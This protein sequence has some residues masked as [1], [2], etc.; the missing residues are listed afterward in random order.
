[1]LKTT[2]VRNLLMGVVGIALQ[3][4]VASFGVAQERIVAPS[5]APIGVAPSPAPSPD[6]NPNLPTTPAPSPLPTPNPAVNPTP[7]VRYVYVKYYI[8]RAPTAVRPTSVGL[9]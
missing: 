6:A 5:V 8:V 9:Y 4:G 1:M 7:G 2:K 3:F